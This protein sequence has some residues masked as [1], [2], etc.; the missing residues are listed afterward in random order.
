MVDAAEEQYLKKKIG[1][2]TV[3]GNQKC[4]SKMGKNETAN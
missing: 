4:N 1:K 2:N 3:S